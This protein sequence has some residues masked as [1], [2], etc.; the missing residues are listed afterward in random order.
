MKVLYLFIF[1]ICA[2]VHCEAQKPGTID[3]RFGQNGV[4]YSNEPSEH[5]AVV[6]QPDGKLVTGGIYLDSN[7]VYN[8]GSL[9]RF[10]PDG[11]VDLSFGKNGFA[12][13]LSYSRVYDLV[14]QSNKKLLVVGDASLDSNEYGYKAYVARFTPNGTP[15][16]TFGVNGITVIPDYNDY[17]RYNNIRLEGDGSIIIAG[18]GTNNAYHADDDFYML[19]HISASGIFDT[20]FGKDGRVRQR[21]PDYNGVRERSLAIQK[22]GKILVGGYAI[23]LGIEDQKLVVSRYRTN[24]TLDTTFGGTGTIFAQ[25]IAGENG[26]NDMA[27]IIVQADRKIVIGATA[28]GTSPG[29]F[30][31]ALRFNS[32]GTPDSSFG[33]KGRAL[34]SFKPAA[35]Q[36]TSIVQQPDGKFILTGYVLTS[37][38]QTSDIALCRVTSDGRIDSAFGVNGTQTTHFTSFEYAACATLQKDGKIVIGGSYFDSKKEKTFALLVRYHGS[39]NAQTVAVAA[40]A[41]EGI[42]RTGSEAFSV[43]MYPNPASRFMTV[44]GL[45]VAA[46]TLVT[47][48]DDLGKTVLVYNTAGAMQYRCDVS[49]LT[50]GVYYVQVKTGDKTEVLKFV[51]E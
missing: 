37:L 36:T 3:K 41:K 7:Y 47:I 38:S 34:V 33:K 18:S 48:T 40:A 51:K 10:L 19:S 35:A 17:S 24:G 8:K 46:Q 11:T 31:A 1:S 16:S 30:M 44:T 13:Q 9:M 2:V 32:D 43:S 5:Y 45:P 22:D 4:S 21:F 12:N 29:V 15:D 6:Q 42:V 50:A 25:G 14:L 23:Y 28:A 20:A 39:A 49:K 26:E 27:G